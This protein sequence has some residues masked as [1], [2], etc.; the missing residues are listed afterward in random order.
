MLRYSNANGPINTGIT[1]AVKTLVLQCDGQPRQTATL[2]MPHREGDGDSTVATF[3]A[4][5]GVPCRFMLEDGFN[6]SY[7]AHF[8][9]YT[10]GRG[11]ESGPL[12]EATYGPLLLS[13][14]R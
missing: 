12:N 2:V 4:H 9:N 8:A 6:M 1:A 13:P 11:G 7:L 5:A 3:T 14:A 10:G